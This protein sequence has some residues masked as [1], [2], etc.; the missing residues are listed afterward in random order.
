MAEIILPGTYIKVFDEGLVSAGAVS[1]G[2]IGIVGTASKGPLNEV[3][4]I[5]SFAEARSHFGEAGSYNPKSD[6]NLSLVR[7]LEQAFNNGGKTVYAVR[8][9]TGSA[10]VAKLDL[11]GGTT[12][13]LTLE[14]Q[15]LGTF[16]NGITATVADGDDGLELVISDATTEEKYAA[17]SV[18]AA[19]EAINERST[20]VS[21]TFSKEGTLSKIEDAP[22]S[23][24][25]DGEKV[26]DKE[27]KTGLELLEN[28]I[29][30]IVLMAG[31]DAASASLLAAHLKKTAGNKRERIGVLG[32]TGVEATDKNVASDRIILASPGIKAKTFDS[33]TQ[34]EVQVGL[35]SSY[36]AAA[37][38]G[39]MAS[40]PV[41]S[42]PTNKVL[43][44]S[45]L[46]D[47]Y[48]TGKLEKLVQNRVLAI[49]QREG[50]RVVKG[51]T[52]ATNTAW[53]QITTRRIVD[54]AIYGVRSGCNPYIGKLNNE[55][56]RNA[57][58]ATLDA[59]LTRMV[60]DEA[61]ISYELDVTATRAEQIQGI[62]QVNMTLRPTFS[63]DFIKVN[64]YL[65]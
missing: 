25:A 51:I 9:G 17:D 56:V 28:D 42:S 2:N 37:V 40:L 63:I 36:M 54:Y 53:H 19:A 23:G 10:K 38:A 43:A 45:G 16:G 33:T 21:A 62:V 35:P 64:M 6:D 60:N 5:S 30:N 31:K 65:G 61:L 46:T 47:I 48:N 44:I 26:G 15:T 24:G 22:L 55:R 13:L 12:K 49:E 39:L 7:T 52:T 3:V 50:F 4:L 14:G 18:T 11:K 59:F 34:K 27:Y 58:K 8:I 57:M 32:A 20:L 1:T 29:I 41:Q